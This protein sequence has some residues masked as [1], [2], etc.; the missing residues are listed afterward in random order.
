VTRGTQLRCQYLILQC[1][2]RELGVFNDIKTRILVDLRRIVTWS[3]YFCLLT[4]CSFYLLTRSS[5]RW[6]GKIRQWSSVHENEKA[7]ARDSWRSN[8]RKKGFGTGSQIYSHLPQCKRL[9][10]YLCY[11]AVSRTKCWEFLLQVAISLRRHHPSMVI[12]KKRCSVEIGF[13]R[14]T[15]NDMNTT[16][17]ATDRLCNR[18]VR[19]FHR[20]EGKGRLATPGV[21]PDLRRWSW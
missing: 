8:L 20:V 18:L 17:G 10:C 13:R 7:G 4:Y 14:H 2:Q 21:Q 15:N 16:L 1:W 9:L 11:T 12:N 6:G 3:G 19:G 5:G